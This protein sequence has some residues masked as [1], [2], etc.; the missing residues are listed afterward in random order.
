M[1]GTR[2]PTL[3]LSVTRHS[4]SFR[5]RKQPP[6]DVHRQMKIIAVS[7]EISRGFDCV[8]FVV[9]FSER[10]YIH[11]GVPRYQIP[12][13]PCSNKW[14]VC[15]KPC[16]IMLCCYVDPSLE[17]GSQYSSVVCRRTCSIAVPSAG[18]SFA[19]VQPCAVCDGDV[20]QR[21]F[22]WWRFSHCHLLTKRRNDKNREH[23]ATNEGQPWRLKPGRRIRIKILI[24]A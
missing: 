24:C 17:D 15:E 22:W 7:V 2:V 20:G 16:D 8:Q 11:V 10:V 1:K 5:N 13:S 4:S 19:D 14:T 21:I 9:V 12:V 6:I 3:Q 18:A 23:K